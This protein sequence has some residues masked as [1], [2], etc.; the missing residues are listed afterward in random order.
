MPW[1]VE[2]CIPKLKVMLDIFKAFVDLKTVIVN[3]YYFNSTVNNVIGQDVPW[4]TILAISV[5]TDNP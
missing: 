5:V 3:T 2:A 1:F 4:L